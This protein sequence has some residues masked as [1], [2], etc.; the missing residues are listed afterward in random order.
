MFY[1]S[2]FKFLTAC[3]VRLEFPT[4]DGKT[5]VTALRKHVFALP[6]AEEDFPWGESVAKIRGKV[7]VFFPS[8]D[9]DGV[10]QLTLKLP[11]SAKEILLSKSASPT[12]YGLGKH[13]W[14]TIRLTAD[15]PGL[16][17]L[18]QLSEESYQAVNAPVKK[19]TIR[20]TPAPAKTAKKS[21]KRHV[22]K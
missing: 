12:G 2:E 1:L 13:G 11:R 9:A 19:K 21:T 7:F 22:R 5:T 20:K 16:D 3:A 17:R 14:V 15:A 8:P 4:V 18:K 10:F 6:G